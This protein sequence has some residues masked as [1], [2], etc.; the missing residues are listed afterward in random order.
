MLAVILVSD[1]YF[2]T[3]EQTKQ[4]RFSQFRSY[5]ILDT[6]DQA[7]SPLSLSFILP[8]GPICAGSRRSQLLPASANERFSHPFSLLGPSSMSAATTSTN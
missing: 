6:M 4:E 1:Y 5:G 2:Q 8:D 3:V 7:Y